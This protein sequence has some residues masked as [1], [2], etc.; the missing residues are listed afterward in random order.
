MALLLAQTARRPL[1]ALFNEAAALDAFVTAT[2]GRRRAIQQRQPAR[3]PAR[4][5]SFVVRSSLHPP[6]H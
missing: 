6:L 2:K 1:P 4:T 5:R 3:P